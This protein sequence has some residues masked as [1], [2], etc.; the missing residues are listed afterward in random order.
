MNKLNILIV[1]DQIISATDIQET[2]E[3]AGHYIT[4]I[5]QTYQDAIKA[6]EKIVPDLAIVDIVLER[7]SAD[8]VMVARD[9]IHRYQIPIIYLTASSESETFRRAAATLP[10][11]YLLKPF[12]HHELAFQIELAYLNWHNQTML[13]AETLF[14]PINKGL[15]KVEKSNVLY[16]LAQGAY[17][18][19]YMVGEEKPYLLTMNLGYLAQ[20]FSLNIFYRLSRS[21]LINLNHIARIDGSEL[22]M[23]AHAARLPIPEN[24]RGQLLKKLNVVRTR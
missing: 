22:L 16:L 8:G 3:K 24:T 19:M 21:L 18:N 11:A 17:V 20:Y 1:E 4:E 5:A 12:R 23:Q 6:V 7:S 9:L 10:A 2:L 13:D 14:L 15:E